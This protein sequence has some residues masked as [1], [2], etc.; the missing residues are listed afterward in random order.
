[1]TEE[2][3]AATQARLSKLLG[4]EVTRAMVREWRAKGYPLDDGPELREILLGQHKCPD[5]LIERA[6]PDQTTTTTG[7]S[8][9]LAVM[10]KSFHNI[11]PLDSL[12]R[13]NRE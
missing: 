3:E 2:T 10:A 7:P 5:W 8:K 13:Q 1:M 11:S 12:A 6:G 4:G 9:E